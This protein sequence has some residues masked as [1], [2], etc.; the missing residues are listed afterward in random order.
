MTY[1]K[2]LM[3]PKKK[4][5]KMP[6]FEREFFEKFPFPFTLDVTETF[7]RAYHIPQLARTKGTFVRFGAGEEK[8]GKITKVVPKGVYVQEFVSDKVIGWKKKG[9]PF[10]VRQKRLERHLGEA[11]AVS[12][13]LLRF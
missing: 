7:R 4:L 1:G 10:F 11:G 2:V 12:P 8:I 9:E 6:F 5:K 3:I 13:E